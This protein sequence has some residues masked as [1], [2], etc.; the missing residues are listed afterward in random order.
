MKIGEVNAKVSIVAIAVVVIF[1][2][3]LIYTYFLTGDQVYLI[4]GIPTI[5]FLFFIP[6]ALNYMSQS[7]YAEIGRAHV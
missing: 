1:S 2:I 3:L 5:V 7:Q 6:M 4:W